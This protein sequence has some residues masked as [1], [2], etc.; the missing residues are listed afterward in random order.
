MKPVLTAIA[1][2]VLWT[3]FM[4]WW[5]GIHS[6]SNIVILG[7]IGLAIGSLF[8]SMA[9]RLKRPDARSS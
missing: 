7:A 3:A 1:Y 5:S 2:S 6:T 9:C 4:V 8:A